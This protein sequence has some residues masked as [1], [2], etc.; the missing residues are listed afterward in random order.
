M[1]KTVKLLFSIFMLVALLIQGTQVFATE[2]D[3]K[4]TAKEMIENYDAVEEVKNEQ[5]SQDSRFVNDKTLLQEE[6]LK[7]LE[8]RIKKAKQK[9][10]K[11]YTFDQILKADAKDFGISEED[12]SKIKEQVESQ[13]IELENLLS[14]FKAI[15]QQNHPIA[16]N[17][18]EE[19]KVKYPKSEIYIDHSVE[20][21]EQDGTISGGGW[22]YCLDDNG[23][24]YQNFITSDCYKAIVAFL[25][26]A[27]DSSLGKMNSNLRY[28]K[29][30][31]RNCS[32]LIG[33]SKYDHTHAWYQQ[34]P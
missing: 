2:V 6:K 3:Y 24:G 7:D 8:E 34:I 19:L 10:E 4:A 22:P 15:G 31:I 32:P 5:A 25:I 9:G 13:K 33:H 30:Y 20:S 1:S 16:K 21:Q 12:M 23:W 17:I 26:C 29:A 28:C 27:S 18:K 14:G 11:F